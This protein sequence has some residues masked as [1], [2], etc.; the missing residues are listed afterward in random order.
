MAQGQAFAG[1]LD[2]SRIGAFGH[3][4]G[5]AAAVLA[6]ARVPAIRAAANL[7]GDFAGAAAVEQPRVPLLYIT[8]QPP[9]RPAVPMSA[10]ED[11]SSEMRRD[12]I[13][14]N[15]ASRSPDAQR[16]RI[17]G[18]FHSNFQDE[19][20]LP[21]SAMPPKLRRAR[22][23]SIDGA[24]GLDLTA[25]LLAGFFAQGMAGPPAEDVASTVAQFPES[26]LQRLHGNGQDAPR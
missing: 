12:R 26:D 14:R 5:G 8:S 7:D 23:G 25:R 15:L 18:L 24:R 4:I 9:N 13:W 20:L 19:A 1:H 3:S 16:V 2:L 17:G 21:A 10:W 22:F 6:A 11:E